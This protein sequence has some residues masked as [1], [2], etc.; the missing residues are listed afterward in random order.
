MTQVSI[1]NASRQLSSL[2]NRA[3]Y[4]REVVTLTSRGKAK[5]VILGV[6]SFQKLVGMSEYA[7][8]ELMP[9]DAFRAAFHRALEEAG[10]S[11]R[12][13]VVELVRE[14]KRELAEERHKV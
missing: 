13:S 3:A 10:Y 7:Q 5:A 12:E 14:V 8:E 1:A 2:V 11:T 6:E 9:L 4:G